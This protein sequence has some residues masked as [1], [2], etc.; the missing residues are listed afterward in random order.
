[1]S[2]ETANQL[3]RDLRD[4]N[5]ARGGKA[6]TA[7]RPSQPTQTSQ[8]PAGLAPSDSVA[9]IGNS[10]ERLR[11][12]A[13]PETGTPMLEPYSRP[14]AVTPLP[15]RPA[16][17][18]RYLQQ[19]PM[20][21]QMTAPYNIPPAVRPPPGARIPIPPGYPQDLLFSQQQQQQ[22]QQGRP[23]IGY[24]QVLP[25]APDGYSSPNYQVN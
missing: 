14:Q 6:V 23:T 17:D 4:I 11:L 10:V 16:P 9:Q 15:D 1:M 3:L 20:Q 8:Y 24:E 25:T 18:P 2:M 13:G 19:Q 7:N 5:R 22:Q 12:T 21:P